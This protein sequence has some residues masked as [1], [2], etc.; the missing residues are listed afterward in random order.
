M[1]PENFIYWLQGYLELNDPKTIDEAQTKMIKEHLQL[2]LKKV[3]PPLIPQ[4]TME[5]NPGKPF[6]WPE[7]FGNEKICSTG[8]DTKFCASLGGEIVRPD[9]LFV[10]VGISC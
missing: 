7:G 3:T 5:L 1:T 6:V 4:R 10:G 9:P 8:S 2:A